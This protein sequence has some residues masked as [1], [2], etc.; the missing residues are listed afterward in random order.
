LYIIIFS[1][2]SFYTSSYVTNITYF[3]VGRHGCME[4]NN[5]VKE[6]LTSQDVSGPTVRCRMRETDVV[7]VGC[8]LRH[9]MKFMEI[10]HGKFLRENL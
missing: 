6:C 2:H 7:H 1:L 3:S 10:H 9:C 5:D 4:S 8:V